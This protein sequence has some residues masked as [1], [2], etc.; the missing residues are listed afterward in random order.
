MKRRTLYFF[1][2]L[3]ILMPVILGASAGMAGAS[4]VVRSTLANG[5]QV[6]VVRN[7]LAPVVTTMVNYLVGSN[8]AP[9]GFPGMA[10]A[11]EHMM[12]R[13]SPGLSGPQLATLIAAMGGSFDADTQQ[14]VTQ[15]FFTVPSEDLEVALHI[16]AVR[17]RGVL[18]SQELWERERGAIEQEV[19]Q[20]YSNPLYLF[21]KRMLS[22]L[23]ERTPYAHDALGTKPSFDETTG[24]MLKEFHTKW[25]A[26]NNAILVVVGDIEPEGTL[27]VV[28]E[29]FESIPSRP[30]PSRPEIRLQP[31]KPNSIMLDSD[32]PYGMAMVAYRLPGYDSPD[33]AAAQ[34]LADVLESERGSLYALVPE[35]KALE[36]GF[37]S[38]FLPKAGYGYAV[39]AFPHGGDGSGLLKEL[40]AIIEKYR[41]QG[42]PSDL[43][44]AAKRREV[45]DLE[46][47]KNSVEGLAS[48]WSQALAVEGRHSPEDDLKAIQAVTVAD[49]NRVA[50]TYLDN[51]TATIG[52]LTPKP[53]GK[54]VA[55]RTFHG[56]ESFAPKETK[57]VPLPEWAKKVLR[58]AS[59]PESIITPKE[60]ILPNGLRL[61]VQP[62]KVS[63]TI[64]L[65]GQVKS[66]PDL[67]TP[68]GQEGVADILDGLFSY[69]TVTLDRLA[70]QKAVDDIAANL[71]AG[72]TFSLEVLE[73]Q[74]DRGVSLLADNI[75]HPALPE[76][77]FKVVQ[78]ET[79]GLVAG[80]LQSPSYLARRALRAGLYP[81]KDPTLRQATPATLSSL[82]LEEVRKYHQTV[83]RPDLTTV[84]LIGDIAPERGR[85]VVEKYF[86]EWKALG[87]KPETDLPSVPLNPPSSASVPDKSRVQD[88]VL[89][90][91]T[92]G[93]N[94]SNP[95]YYLLQVGNHVLSGAFYATRLYH[96]LREEAGLV[97]SVESVLDVGKT[98]GLF[99]VVFACDPPN[100]SK[101]RSMV[102][103]NLRKMQ[104]TPMTPSELRQAKTLLL[105]GIPLSQSST[106]K[107][108]Q[109]LLGL[110]IQGL[111]LDEPTRAAKRYL[112]STEADVQA[113][114]S[115][116]IR[117]QAFVQVSLGPERK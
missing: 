82:T 55:S 80:K 115:K 97:Y 110:S 77:A 104:T 111:P 103:E 116:W 12:F 56:K 84:V 20:D 53:A 109:V 64:G 44:E 71:S 16:E 39:A 24:A 59:L 87:P 33:F 19:A 86:G 37:S 70:F 2:V 14:T 51:P 72:S 94:R 6:V 76:E 32:L 113:A 101:A 54:A 73:D 89:L 34:V 95:D 83:F 52:V 17:M 67:Q 93:L 28:K 21:Q 50:R 102:E 31:L 47:Q 78:K 22:S 81:K 38:S 65:Y 29:L 100:V 30:V 99:E 49:V 63:R 68:K 74:F 26:P 106:E 45:A 35:G 27:K 46:F 9:E 4:D 8:E 10:H 61:I 13:G 107:I 3:G 5:L 62:T 85:A 25:Y 1:F 114:F 88:L 15:Y 18:D 96:D 92:L 108:A 58:P 66:N 79:I 7:E 69:G 40:K 57:E 43:V 112:E 90:A 98:R 105:R 42:L 91:Q 117:P 11:Q 60:M 23:F 41:E 48:L 36:A 75:L